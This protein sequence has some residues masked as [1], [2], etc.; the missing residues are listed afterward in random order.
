MNTVTHLHFMR[1]TLQHQIKDYEAG[2]STPKGFA[3]YSKVI[4]PSTVATSIPLLIA[5]YKI[6]RRRAILTF[7]PVPD[8]PLRES[9]GL[10]P[11]AQKSLLM[12]QRRV[13]QRLQLSG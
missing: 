9:T 6:F 12:K 4:S 13:M 5:D 2:F 1:D 8:A 7:A 11:I 3:F 10:S